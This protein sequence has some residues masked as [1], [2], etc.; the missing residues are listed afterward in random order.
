MTYKGKL[1]RKDKCAW[2]WKGLFD[3]PHLLCKGKYQSIADLLFY[4]FVS[5]CIAYVV[6]TTDLLVWKIPNQSRRRSAVQWHFHLRSITFHRCCAAIAAQTSKM[7]R[8]SRWTNA[9]SSTTPRHYRFRRLAR[10]HDGPR[11]STR[12]CWASARGRSRF[13]SLQNSRQSQKL[14]IKLKLALSCRVSMLAE[15]LL[16]SRQNG[17]AF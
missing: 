2:S 8:S 1:F 5:L 6:V 4:L 17:T 15:A 11:P 13:G 16:R 10:Q 9:S 12:S 7:R 14:K 3:Y